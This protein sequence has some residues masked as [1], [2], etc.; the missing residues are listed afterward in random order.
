[1]GGATP[2]STS[3]RNR[4]TCSRWASTTRVSSSRCRRRPGVACAPRSSSTA[5]LAEGGGEDSRRRGGWRATAPKRGAARSG[6]NCRGVVNP[7]A[8][9]SIYIQTLRDPARLAGNVGLVSQSGS[10]MI[11]LLADCR[12]FGWSQAISS[13]NEAVL[14]AVDF[15]DYLIDDPATR[16][17]ALFLESVREPDRFV[18]AL[19]RAAD[20]SKPVVVLKVGRS[21]RARR[22][23]PS[24]T[25]GLP[26][27]PPGF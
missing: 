14:T 5:G 19:D 21:E 15:L 22:A 20:R 26:R 1:A 25:G 23:I 27:Q 16:I 13:G 4:L 18:P 11:S 12:R 3:C 8:R 17:I 6:A 7:H 10:I 24:H 9:S 2:R